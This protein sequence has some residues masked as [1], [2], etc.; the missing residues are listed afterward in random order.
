M[1]GELQQTRYDQLV[2]RVGGIIGPGSKVAE[3]LPELFPTLDVERVPLELLFLAGWRLGMGRSTQPALAANV[4]LAQC[5]NPVDSG[6]LMV[7]ERVDF[8]SNTSSNIGWAVSDVALTNVVANPEQRDTRIGANELTT[9]Q[10]REVQQVAVPSAVGEVIVVADQN[11]PLERPSGLFVLAPGTG[12]TF[13]NL[14]ANVSFRCSFFWRERVA[15]ESEL[16]FP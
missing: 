6:Q 1:P 7:V 14:T 15:L 4:N 12:A 11:F 10:V 5:F 16:L 8:S 3:A 13:F 2:R 9:G